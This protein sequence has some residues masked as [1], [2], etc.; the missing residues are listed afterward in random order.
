MTAGPLRRTV[1]GLGLLAIVPIAIQLASGAI[2]P[3]LAAQRATVVAVV[4]VVLGRVVTRCVAG[5]LR[6]VE[7]EHPAAVASEAG[8]EG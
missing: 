3:E 5:T 2:Q 4:A 6:R 1:G 7:R 8:S